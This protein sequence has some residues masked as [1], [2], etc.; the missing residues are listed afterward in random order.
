[1]RKCMKEYGI[2]DRI[3]ELMWKQ[4]FFSSKIVIKWKCVKKDGRSTR[5]YI[6]IAKPCKNQ[7]TMVHGI[8]SELAT[9]VDTEG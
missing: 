2:Y 3:G 6:F 4:D 7:L 5:I 1:M 9:A 8:K